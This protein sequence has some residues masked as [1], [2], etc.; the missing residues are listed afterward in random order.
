MNLN[1]KMF[2][3]I[4]LGIGQNNSLTTLQVSGNKIDS[5]ALK[6]IQIIIKFVQQL[7]YIDLTGNKFNSLDQKTI[8]ILNHIKNKIVLVGEAWQNKV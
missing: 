1:T 4:C 2:C 7:D 3:Q 5:R 6:S 8:S